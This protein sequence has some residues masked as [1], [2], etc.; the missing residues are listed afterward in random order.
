MR[1]ELTT[2]L[3]CDR[4]VLKRPKHHSRRYPPLS[5]A[6]MRSTRTS[7]TSATPWSRA[8]CRRASRPSPRRH[9][10]RVRRFLGAMKHRS[11]RTGPRRHRIASSRSLRSLERRTAMEHR[12]RS[13]RQKSTVRRGRPWF[14]RFRRRPVLLCRSLVRGVRW[15]RSTCE[16][17]SARPHAMSRHR[18]SSPSD[19]SR[20][21]R[22]PHRPRR[23]RFG[24]R[25]RR[26]RSKTT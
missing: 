22:S 25:G 21:V 20:C 2:R 23:R 24:T 8:I 26:C 9:A 5:N 10:S 12:G 16:S 17:T 15:L 13:P 11:A 7:R 14:P 4:H 1:S 18:S 6:P 3:G 19:E